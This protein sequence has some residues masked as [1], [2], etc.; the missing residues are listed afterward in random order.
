MQ[1]FLK[2]LRLLSEEEKKQGIKIL[3]L[4]LILSVLE[5]LGVASVMPFLAVLGNP[6]L[7][8]SNATINSIYQTTSIIGIGS[9]EHFLA[10]L[11]LCSFFLIVL[12]AIYRTFTIY[13]L[14]DFIEMRRHTFSLR[15]FKSFL[16]RPYEFFIG[17]HSGELSK[18]VLSEVDELVNNIFLSVVFMIS[19]SVVAIGILSLLIYSNPIL[20]FCSGIVFGGCYALIFALLRKRAV[21]LGE[22]MVSN[23]EKRFLAT[24]EVFSG[25]KIIKLMRNEGAFLN[26]FK[27]PSHDFAKVQS[28][29]RTMNQVPQYIVEALGFGGIIVIALVLL[30]LNGSDSTVIGEILP[31][32][33]LYAFASYRLQ[34]ALRYIFQGFI[35]LKYGEK[36]IDNLVRDFYENDNYGFSDRGRVAGHLDIEKIELESVSYTYPEGEK[37]SIDSVDLI[38]DKG[39]ALGIVGK[40]GSGKSTLID[41]VLGLLRPTSGRLIVNGTEINEDNLEAYQKSLGYVPQDIVLSDATIAEN[42]A[43]GVRFEDIDTSRIR[44]VCQEA[45]LTELIFAS[46]PEGLNTVIGEKGIRLS[47]G[48]R[49]R[50]GIARAL[51]FSPKVLVLDEATSALDIQTEATIIKNMKTVGKDISLIVV[52]HRLSTIRN[53]DQ[54]IVLEK[55]GVSELVKPDS[56]I[57]KYSNNEFNIEWQS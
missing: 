43:Y 40:T 8:D 23:N 49:Q 9:Q 17:R 13:M 45:A 7:I 33:G 52:A 12:S 6:D 18:G 16:S 11:G 21:S 27:A 55:G 30:F 34:P 20:A 4:V 22:R 10:F 31:T 15:L 38:L 51:Y 44:K 47:G 42:I 50:I 53:C 48:E 46:L 24:S 25:I 32:L 2:L 35:S 3:F 36:A 41:L 14:N 57:N 39:R 56:L 29:R 37:S 54:I 26:I 19:S 1:A 5:T 28:L